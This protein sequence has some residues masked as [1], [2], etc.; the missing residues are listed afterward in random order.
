MVRRRC[1]VWVS[2]WWRQGEELVFIK[3]KGCPAGGR[4]YPP[5]VRQGEKVISS[6]V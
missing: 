2:W 4:R 6:P 3:V 1:L 5:G